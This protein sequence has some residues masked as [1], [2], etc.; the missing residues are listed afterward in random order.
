MIKRMRARVCWRGND[1]GAVAVEAALV[2]P[3]IVLILFGIIEFSLLLRDYV[4]LTSASRTG[5]R[6]ASAE[7]RNAS[8]ADDAAAA[9]ARAGL[10]MPLSSIEELWVYQAND[11]G[12]PGADGSTGFSSSCPDNCVRYSYDAGSSSFVRTGPA[13]WAPST[14]NACAGDPDATSVGI[15]LKAKHTYVT[16]LVGD[17]VSMAE[18]AVMRFE[19]FPTSAGQ[20][21]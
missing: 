7:P 9:V 11:K 12:Y 3:V 20:C 13:N 6:T 21:K 4:S 2:I 5:A 17:T 16:K 10:A 18:H 1:R 19:P 15:Y 8:F 14:I